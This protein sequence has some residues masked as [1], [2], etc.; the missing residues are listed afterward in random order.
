MHCVARQNKL[1]TPKEKD[2][3]NKRVVHECDVRTRDPESR[4]DGSPTDT[5]T[6]MQS[7]SPRQGATDHRL[8]LWRKRF[9]EE[10]AF[11]TVCYVLLQGPSEN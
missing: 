5:Q 10:V 3:V 8:K 6:D 4:R 2:E 11:A 7:R 1:E 9:A